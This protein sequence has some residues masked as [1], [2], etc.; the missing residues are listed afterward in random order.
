MYFDK[1]TDFNFLS[2]LNEAKVLNSSS[3]TKGCSAS[4]TLNAERKVILQF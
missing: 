2:S 1:E 4:N 3:Q